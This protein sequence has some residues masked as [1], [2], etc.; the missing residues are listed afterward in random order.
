MSDT[1]Y[2]CYESIKGNYW[3]CQGP[4]D[5]TI[6]A[7][8]FLEDKICPSR[9]FIVPAPSYSPSFIRQ[10]IVINN[11]L[12]TIQPSIIFKEPGNSSNT[13]YSIEDWSAY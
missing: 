9:T 8:A 6:L 7:K 5:N 12:K 2:A 11:L 10:Q 1:Y 3:T 13:P 4:Y